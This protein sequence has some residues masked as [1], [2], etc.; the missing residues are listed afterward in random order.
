[1]IADATP[2]WLFQQS[3]ALEAFIATAGARPEFF[4]ISQLLP[5]FSVR[6]LGSTDSEKIIID[7]WH[8]SPSLVTRLRF[9]EPGGP[10]WELPFPVPAD[11]GL[12]HINGREYYAPIQRLLPDGSYRRI[13]RCLFD[14]WH[15]RAFRF[16]GKEGP[17]L[18]TLAEIAALVMT[19]S[20]DDR[21]VLIQSLAAGWKVSWFDRE[22]LSVLPPSQ[23]PLV[24]F[25]LV[26]LRPVEAMA[27][28]WSSL[29]PDPIIQAVTGG[30][31]RH[32]ARLTEVKTFRT[33]PEEG[34]KYSRVWLAEKAGLRCRQE[35]PC[36]TSLDPFYM[37]E[38]N[39]IGLTRHTSIGT[40]VTK[41]GVL[42]Y[43]AIP[44]LLEAAQG[45]GPISATIPF[46]RNND[47]RRVLMGC[48]MLAQAAMI[49]KAEPPFVQTGA[50]SVLR[51]IYPQLFKQS[52]VNL[53]IGFMFWH[54]YNYEDA[55][56]V[57]ESAAAKLRTQTV[58]RVTMPVPAYL[59]F[60]DDD[61]DTN[62]R[63]GVRR[64][65][66]RVR[67]GDPLI[68]VKCN[69]QRLHVSVPSRL[70]QPQGSSESEIPWKDYS[71][72]SPC[73]GTILR[74]RIVPLWDTEISA[75]NFRARV[76]FAIRLD[77][78]L[79]IGDK[80]C[81]RHGNKGVV[82]RIVP[83]SEMPKW[84]GEPLDVLFNPIG[85]LN[86]G[87]YGQMYEAVYGAYL[88][89]NPSPSVSLERF[90]TNP[91]VLLEGICRA[92]GLT[93]A[94]TDE[95]VFS[96]EG[97]EHR[98]QCV[99]GINYILRL[100]HY[101]SDKFKVHTTGKYSRR[102]GQPPRGWGQKYGE[103]ERWCLQAHGAKEILAELE[104]DGI[105]L[106]VGRQ[107]Q[108][109]VGA[110]KS[111][112]RETALMAQADRLE[113]T[114]D[115][116]PREPDSVL[117]EYLRALSIEKLPCESLRPMNFDFPTG[118]EILDEKMKCPSDPD[119]DHRGTTGRLHLEVARRRLNSPS[120]E[121]ECNLKGGIYLDLGR[122]F[123]VTIGSP[124]K[125]KNARKKKNADQDNLEAESER[126]FVFRGRY[127]PLLPL[128]LRWSSATEKKS[129]LTMQYEELVRAARRF[130]Q[131]SARP[132]IGASLPS[133]A[134]AQVARHL[135]GVLKELIE[136]VDGKHGVA[137]SVV[138]AR[139][140]EYSAR[141]VIVPEPALLLDEVS[142]PWDCVRQIYKD[143]LG[144]SPGV[145]DILNLRAAAISSNSKPELVSIIDDAIADQRVLLNRNPSLAKYSILAFRPRVHFDSYVMKICP[146]VTSAFAA[147]FDGDTMTAVRLR[148]PEAIR[149][150]EELLP[151]ANLVSSVDGDP[152]CPATKEFLLGLALT[153][154]KPA[155][156]SCLADT[157]S[158]KGLSAIPPCNIDQASAV[159]SHYFRTH[160]AADS[161]SR[162]RR[163]GFYTVLRDTALRVTM[164]MA[165]QSLLGPVPAMV[166]GWDSHLK[167][168]AAKDLLS[169]PAAPDPP[170]L[171]GVKSETQRE[172]ANERLKLMMVAE[173]QKGLLG[174]LIR[175]F[176]YRISAR[177]SDDFQRTLSYCQWLTA[178][179]TQK[180][181]SPK[182][183][184]DAL[185]KS[186]FERSLKEIQKTWTDCHGLAKKLDV[187]E[188]VLINCVRS[189]PDL[190]SPVTGI[191]RFYKSP[192]ETL[193]EVTR[194]VV[195]TPVLEV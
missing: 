61:A 183:A 164:E 138:L 153:L 9:S 179:A 175:Q 15:N 137:R 119:C 99:V 79:Q 59:E 62:F 177:N 170:L 72:E 52:G 71:F 37:P 54:G 30:A 3:D 94:A 161:T 126:A 146:F 19:L 11:D 49:S 103:M 97:K 90:E 47:P 76:E 14:L 121:Q 190:K 189:I 104:T 55:V 57:S 168:R 155:W 148:R 135:E 42:E 20:D 142:L 36:S 112:S 65:G 89:R 60:V 193:G 182:S 33:Q 139:R 101:A 63:G 167:S 83:D 130:R 21:D 180:A 88:S 22:A 156:Y 96:L 129:S 95:V 98:C 178:K 35:W 4:H 80:L 149:E 152:V 169:G 186:D 150:A 181:L 5:D 187:D 184:R 131:E 147:D 102:T 144:R 140:L 78:P 32:P 111:A 17:Q 75:S 13:D 27:H 195:P 44:E 2:S 81:N 116:T 117:K 58:R 91:I 82:S 18:H 141:M 108:V 110:S 125:R 128:S 12:F 166:A 107:E 25:L 6:Y 74:A 69:P 87:N 151:S 136:Q 23:Q 185:R 188:T 38:G 158:S 127:L 122:P 1:M 66:S 176:Y 10:E 114:Y 191:N 143:I 45:L 154:S 51:K 77:R 157:L 39:S 145:A 173:T 172:F 48:N 85:V 93:S 56:V 105:G 113:S 26:A 159:L 7:Q 53:R 174:A 70:Y 132:H 106:N 24:L 192:A 109:Q 28:V 68:R 160:L 34:T 29:R 162:E 100:P 115:P 46:L 50:E 123:T 171:D 73:A 165:Y 133:K 40:V 41:D 84:R 120:F 16:R 64:P 118:V 86:R 43:K 194:L 124:S 134:E 92:A 31:W 163:N 8:A 67:E